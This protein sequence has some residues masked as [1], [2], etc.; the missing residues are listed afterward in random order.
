MRESER[1]EKD[2]RRTA[3]NAANKQSHSHSQIGSFHYN[4]WRPSASLNGKGGPVKG[5]PTAPLTMRQRSICG[6]ATRGSGLFFAGVL[7]VCG[8]C[9]AVGL[10]EFG[11]GLL[12]CRED[13]TVT[14][15]QRAGV[16]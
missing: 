1:I 5:W 9:R 6:L 11:V 3:H 8:G 7:C 16:V 13:E 2:Q 10:E 15:L 12:A 4:W 14:L